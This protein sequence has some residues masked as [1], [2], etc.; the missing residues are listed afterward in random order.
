M[1]YCGRDFTPTEIDLI[2]ELLTMPQ[3]NRA[4][5]SREVC[6]RLGW[7]RENG[8]LKDMSCR[9]AL[10]RM[11]SDGLITLPPPRNP[12]PVAYRSYP[13]IEPAVLEPVTIPNINLATLNVDPV[14]TRADSLLWN[15]YMERHHYLGHQLMPG[16]QLRYFVRAAGH[17]VA[18][19]GF[20]ASAWNIKPRDQIIGW[21]RDQRQRN[22][23]LTVNNARFLILPWIH[24]KNLASRILALV[25]RRL[26]DDWQARYA[27]R[28]VLLETFVEK[29]R[30]TGTCYKA[31]NWRHLGDTQGRGKLDVRHRNAQPIKSIWIFPLTRHLQ[32]QLCSG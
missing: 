4:C 28:P 2:R 18:A 29:P 24:R 14:L 20:G 23:H 31:A 12:K 19:L 27:Y 7:R 3:M 6:E 9:V 11:R 5:L 21:T 13:P 1:R 30:F 17:I 22:L 8:G 26:P 10:L 16:A 25:S 15:A 32:R